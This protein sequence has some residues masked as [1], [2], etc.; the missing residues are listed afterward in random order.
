MLNF[1]SLE[2][3]KEF[4]LFLPLLLA[5]KL[6]GEILNSSNLVQT[7]APKYYP[8]FHESN[9]SWN[10]HYNK[11]CFEHNLKAIDELTQIHERL[12]LISEISLDE[13]IERLLI[14]PDVPETIQ[15]VVED[16]EDLYREYYDGIKSG[17]VSYERF[18]S[19]IDSQIRFVYPTA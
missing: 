15:T 1:N 8:K 4:R 11:I 9:L 16:N 2:A 3:T 14:K 5:H 12:N 6:S 17:E 10:Y 19:F 13:L 7:A 18:K